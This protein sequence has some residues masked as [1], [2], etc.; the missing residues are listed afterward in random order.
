MKKVMMMK[1]YFWLLPFLIINWGNALGQVKFEKEARLKTEEVPTPAL[2][3][4]QQ[5]P[6]ENKIKWYRETALDRTSVEAKTKHKEKKHSIEFA[7]TGT[8][9]DVEIQID[10]SE[11]PVPTQCTITD[12]LDKTYQI[13]KIRKIQIQYTGDEKALLQQVSSPKS[14]PADIVIKYE[15]V[16]QAKKDDTPKLLEYLFS[17]T[18]EVLE[19]STITF[20]NTDNLEY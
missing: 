2:N 5:M 3:L 19:K 11:L 4:V 15:I 14:T 17:E 8:I 10:W 6:F 13:A 1:Q 20:K 9:E 16:L 18:G 12:Y 7:E